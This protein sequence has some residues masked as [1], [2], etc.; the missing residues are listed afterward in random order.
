MAIFLQNFSGSFADVE[1][2]DHAFDSVE[3]DE[4]ENFWETTARSRG[5]T[6]HFVCDQV[7]FFCNLADVKRFRDNLDAAGNRDFGLNRA[8]NDYWVSSFS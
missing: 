2:G 7:G 6:Y 8:C 5:D 3:V 4:I 1:R